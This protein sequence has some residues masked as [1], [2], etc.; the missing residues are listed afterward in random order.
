[1]MR[2]SIFSFYIQQQQTKSDRYYTLHTLF[3]SFPTS[4]SPEKE[5]G[6]DYF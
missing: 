3:L 1:M 6:S 2:L 5:N 4:M